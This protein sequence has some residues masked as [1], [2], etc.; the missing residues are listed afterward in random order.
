MLRLMRLALIAG[1]E[2]NKSLKNEISVG[3]TR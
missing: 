3:H 2:D 1:V